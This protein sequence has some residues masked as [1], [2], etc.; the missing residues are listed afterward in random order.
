MFSCCFT[1][2]KLEINQLKQKQKIPQNRFA[3]L[4]DDNQT[5]LVHYL[6]T[7]ETVLLPQKY[8]CYPFLADFGREQ[9]SI[10]MSNKLKRTVC[11]SLD[12]FF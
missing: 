9:F 2:E 5:K 4:T 7:F 11:Q 12:F 10:C 6:E 1:Q 8:D 3:T